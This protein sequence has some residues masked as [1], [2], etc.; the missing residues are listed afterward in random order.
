MGYSILVK[1][2][3]NVV[4]L[5]FLLARKKVCVYVLFLEVKST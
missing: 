2:L 4:Y 3:S 1:L 5:F